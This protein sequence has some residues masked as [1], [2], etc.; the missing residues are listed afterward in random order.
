MTSI[1][2][3]D[4]DNTL[5][6]SEYR[7]RREALKNGI[8]VTDEDEDRYDFYKGIGLDKNT[9][10]SLFRTAWSNPE[11]IPAMTPTLRYITQKLKKLGYTIWVITANHLNT[12]AE[13]KNWLANNGIAYD[14]FMQVA[15]PIDKAGLADILIEDYGEVAKK[16]A[17]L[18]KIAILIKWSYNKD[19]ANMANKNIKI[20]KDWNEIFEYLLELSESNQSKSL[21]KVR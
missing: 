9:L 12:P 18:G 6:N 3:I 2:A 7:F 4:L 17:E 16:Q 19:V 1:I 20:A 10:D 11:S 13:L 5:A 15:D 21:A 8:R 14:E